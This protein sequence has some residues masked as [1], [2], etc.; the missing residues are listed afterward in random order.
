MKYP[1]VLLH[2]FTG[3]ADSWRIL[4]P[5]LEKHYPIL[6]PEIV[7]HGQAPIPDAVSAYTM[8]AESAR[9]LATLPEQFYLLG[10]SMGGRLALYM[11]LHSPQRIKALILES[12]TAGLQTEAERAARR[13]S[14]EALAD[15]IEREGLEAFVNYWESLPLWASQTQLS[16]ATRQN[17]RE[18]RLRNQVK[19]LAHSLRGMGTGAM[20]NLWNNLPNLVIP[21]KLLV[22]AFDTKFVSLNQAM[23]T[24]LPQADLTILDGAGHSV[25]LEQPAKYKKLVLEFLDS[26]VE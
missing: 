23:Q 4:R 11:A 13:Q 24:Q 26:L 22:G 8:E 21:V 19:G 5:E 12:T 1:L 18:Q 3:S 10:Y 9:L 15:R 14:D 17:L 16:P 2:G 25:H 6:T 20:P 7:G